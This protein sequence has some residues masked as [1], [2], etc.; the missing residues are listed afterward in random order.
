MN[1]QFIRSLTIV[2]APDSAM[3]YEP[4]GDS[5]FS[6]TMVLKSMRI[7]SEGYGACR[8]QYCISEPSLRPWRTTM[9]KRQRLAG[10][11]MADITPRMRS[12]WATCST[13]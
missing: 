11:K 3:A 4:A 10:N 2:R 13:V 1:R 8:P 7:A 9:A 12:G 6:A 5:W